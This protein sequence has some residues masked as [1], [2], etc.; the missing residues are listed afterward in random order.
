[1]RSGIRP[2]HAAG[3]LLMMR[4]SRAVPARV[5]DSHGARI[6]LAVGLAGHGRGAAVLRR[7]LLVVWRGH[8]ATDAPHSA[9]A[10][11][12]RRARPASAR[13]RPAAARTGAIR[14]FGADLWPGHDLPMGPAA[15]GLGPPRSGCRHGPD[16]A[17]NPGAGG[18]ERRAFLDQPPAAAHPPAAPLSPAAS[19]F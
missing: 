19:P 15:A 10:G 8:V 12:G 7:H 4:P 6:P 9:G 17:R 3:R 2:W 18:V 1:R 16:R 11:R 14:H 5:T 13:S